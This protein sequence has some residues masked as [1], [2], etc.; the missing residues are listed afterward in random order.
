MHQTQ[1]C[2]IFREIVGCRKLTDGCAT[3]DPKSLWANEALSSWG[4]VSGNKWLIEVYYLLRNRKSLLS[5][6]GLYHDLNVERKTPM[7]MTCWVLGWGS[8]SA[9]WEMTRGGKMVVQICLATDREARE[10]GPCCSS[11]FLSLFSS[12][13]I[14]IIRGYGP[15]QQE[16]WAWLAKT[17]FV[18]AKTTI[19]LL[20][21]VVGGCVMKNKTT[22]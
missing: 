13:A 12:P 21:T 5:A 17:V 3:H 7:G 18:T 9:F 1:V 19:G 15:L 14:F 2:F 4:P 22:M 8:S 11:C 20:S 6:V 10:I 16:G